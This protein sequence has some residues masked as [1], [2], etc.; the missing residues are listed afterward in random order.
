MK[1]LKTIKH[2]SKLDVLLGGRRVGGLAQSDRG[3]IWFEYDPG[4]IK[5]GFGLS[6]M[7]QFD[8]KLGAFKP[9]DPLFNGLH[10]VFDDALPD[11]WGLM[12][13]DRAMK[14]NLDWDPHQ[15]SPL[16]RLAYIGNRAMGALEFRPAIADMTAPSAPSL[17]SL[18]QDAMLVQEGTATEV[19]GA[20]YLHGG[21][22]GGA[23]PKVTIAIERDGDRCMSGFGEIPQNFDHW[24]VKFRTQKA[25]PDCMGRIEL[26]YARMAAAA[27]IDM[28]PSRLIS[29]LVRGKKEDFFAVQRFDRVGNSK[30]HVIS[31]GGML[32]ISHRTASIDYS[33]LLKA[34]SF[35][36]KDVTEV[37]KAF[38]LMAFNVLA[39]NKDDHVKNFAFIRG[40]KAWALTPAYDLTF[41]G[42]I[43]NQHTTAVCGEGLPTL[44]ALG[45]IAE[46]L[47]ISQWQKVVREVHEAVSSWAKLAAELQ[48]PKPIADKYRRAMESSP[49]F[50]EL[51]SR[52]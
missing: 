7:K 45:K 43:N 30:R 49:C 36:T 32:E 33:A 12:L 37:A 1:S 2:T 44:G 3:E 47:Q 41:S 20:L 18:A 4:W 6:P 51:I 8:L 31:L 24:I 11:G 26:A 10:G 46:D 15:I 16:D 38:R 9:K 50:A 21:S 48:V 23:R 42:G 25:D 5:S 35:V 19:L 34:V 29:A 39:H 28:P 14:K 22:P 40:D 27:K 13:M 17:E 52:S